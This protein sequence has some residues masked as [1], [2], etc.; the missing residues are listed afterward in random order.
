ME[1]ISEKEADPDDAAMQAMAAEMGTNMA[2]GPAL[3]PK[4]VEVYTSI[5]I[6]LKRY[7][8][9]KLPKAFK[10][11][12]ALKNWEEIVWVTQPYE[13]SAAATFAATRIFA[14]NLN[15]HMAQR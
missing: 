2:P 15:P 11:I 9:G 5:G 1:K 14:S 6:M 3:N 13:W 8:A 7:S 4:V 12:P 10:I